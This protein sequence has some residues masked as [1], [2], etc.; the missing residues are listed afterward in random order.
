MPRIIASK[1]GQLCAAA[2][3]YASLPSSSSISRS[4]SAS[5]GTKEAEGREADG[6]GCGTVEEGGGGDDDEAEAAPEAP[7]VEEG[8]VEGGG[9]PP[10]AVRGT[11]MSARSAAV[12]AG[13]L[14]VN[15]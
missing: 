12:V 15:G 6:D 10:S 13:R 1:S 3:L 7:K 14:P 2:R 11:F 9:L 4:I 8:L 5:L